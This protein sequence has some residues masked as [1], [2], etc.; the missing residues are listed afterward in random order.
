MS[1]LSEP[2]YIIYLITNLVNGKV[3]VGQTRQKLEKRWSGHLSD[4]KREDQPLYRAMRKHGTENFSIE[5][6]VVVDS[7][8][9]ADYQERIWILLFRAHVSQD[10]YVCT[11]GG[12]GRTGPSPEMRWKRINSRRK[13]LAKIQNVITSI[14]LIFPTARYSICTSKRNG[15]ADKSRIN[16][17]VLPS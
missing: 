2:T 10:G 16:L 14:D 9:Q 1:V 15:L 5:S 17:D 7:Q 4:S 6:V 3:Y 12:D 11:W 13:T 8:E